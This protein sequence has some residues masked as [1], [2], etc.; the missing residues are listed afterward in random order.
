[1]E[2]F[3][4]VVCILVLLIGYVVSFL[5]GNSRMEEY[6]LLR[7]QGVKN[8]NAALLFLL[9]QMVLVFLGNLLGDVLALLLSADPGTVLV[10][11]GILLAAYLAGAA[12]A[13]GRIGKNSVMRLLSSQ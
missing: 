8:R 10:V 12:A 1:M 13:Y 7:L 2:S 6:A 4:P 3:F 5:S 11:N 9:E